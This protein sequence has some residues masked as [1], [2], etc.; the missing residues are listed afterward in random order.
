MAGEWFHGKGRRLAMP[1]LLLAAGC[2]QP[3]AQDEDTAGP[4]RLPADLILTNAAI[5]TLNPDQ[6][7]AEA[8]AIR[9]GRILDVGTADHI[10]AGYR[11]EVVDLEGQMMLP[12]FHDAHSHPIAGGVQMLQCDLT[13]AETVEH[14]LAAIRACHRDKPDTEDPADDWLVGGGWNLSLFPD[15]NP[16][17]RLLD[18]IVGARPVY[19]EGED[20]HSGWVSS[21][22][23][24]RAGITAENRIRPSA[25]SSAT[26]EA[27]PPAP[28]GSR[29][30]RWSGGW[31]P[32]SRT[33][34]AWRERWPP[35]SWPTPWASLPSS[36]RRWVPRNSKPGG[37][38]SRRAG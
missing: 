34:S 30:R 29:P 6:P 22:A 1:M 10:A 33:S 13:E 17:K 25:S 35:W 31:Y 37:A 19:L 20:G 5:Y 8:L 16:H 38:W 2:T 23:L 11:G 27:C 9:D 36:R 15:A 28:C 32:R 21:E 4:D 26:S 14:T 7:R 12:G 18:D 24:D 3:V